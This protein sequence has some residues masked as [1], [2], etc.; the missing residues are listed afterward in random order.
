MRRV[1]PAVLA[2]MMLSSACAAHGPV[3]KTIEGPLDTVSVVTIYSGGSEKAI[4]DVFDMLEDV[5]ARM[6]AVDPA[7][8]LGD[9]GFDRR[10]VSRDTYELIE[11]AVAFGRD[12]NGAF[13]ITIRPVT[14]LWGIGTGNERVPAREEIDEALA[15][16]N[17]RD[18]ELDGANGV[19]L[20][21]EGMKLDL[22]AVAKGYAADK[23]AEILRAAGV[24]SAIIDL[25][26][27]IYFLGVKSG[28]APWR[29]GVRNPEAGENGFF[30]TVE[31]GADTAVV[32]SGAYERFFESGGVKY[33][34]I[35]DPATG[36]PAD[37]GLMSVTIIGKN[38]CEADALSTACFVLGRERA[39]ALLE[40]LGGVEG[41]F[42]S[43]ERE[44][45]ITP[46]LEGVFKL[47][48][49]RFARADE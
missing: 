19:K 1:L 7:S 17:Y 30:C 13:D 39:T 44:V 28:G 42:V 5:D 24:K 18:I 6:T 48:D 46:G 20:A 25:G 11:R 14:E 3:S 35:I 32:T 22:G 4:A 16:V 37:S 47:T 31:L 26:G 15:Y 36:C 49:D 41:I 9:I 10:E 2:V 8:E 29:V 33:H 45:Y 23:A 12:T 34:H 40:N 27:N 38:G 21:R 43:D